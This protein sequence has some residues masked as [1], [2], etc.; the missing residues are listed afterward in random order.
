MIRHEKRAM[1]SKV[2]CFISW[3]DSLFHQLKQ[4]WKNIY[5]F[6]FYEI[7]N[8]LNIVMYVINNCKKAAGMHLLAWRVAYFTF[9]LPERKLGLYSNNDVLKMAQFRKVAQRSENACIFKAGFFSGQIPF[10]NTDWM[11]DQPLLF[12]PS[13]QAAVGHQRQSAKQTRH[14]GTMMF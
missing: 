12:Q 9:L 10:P 7:S 11:L 5:Y 14:V 6:L 2:P 13:F 3:F 1:R 4:N 8:I